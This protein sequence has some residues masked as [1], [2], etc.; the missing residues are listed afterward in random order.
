MD[1]RLEGSLLLYFRRVDDMSKTKDD[2]GADMRKLHKYENKY[3]YSA[4]VYGYCFQ[5]QPIVGIERGKDSL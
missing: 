2:A 3:G 4:Q 1:V 5:S